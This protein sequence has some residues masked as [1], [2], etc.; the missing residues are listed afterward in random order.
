MKITQRLIPAV[1]KDT[2]PGIKMVPQYITIH[3]TDNTSP[4][5]NAE[6]HARLQERGNDRT[7]SWHLQIDDKE[8]IQSIPFDELAWAAGDGR[9]G[10]GNTKS[11]HIEICVN[12]DGNFKKS[13]ENAAEITKQLMA[14]YNIPITKVVQHNHWSGKS[15]PRFL[16]S[17]DKGVSWNDFIS[18]VQSGVKGV[19]NTVVQGLGVIEM[20]DNSVVR[21]SP[22]AYS[23]IVGNVKKGDKFIVHTVNGDWF[24]IGGWVYKDQVILEWYDVVI[25]GFHEFEIDEALAQVKKAFPN[26]HI[27]KRQQ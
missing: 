24:N 9:N 3:E 15:C 20:S 18:M 1:N 2:R 6:A 19:E 5:A 8:A 17:G 11:I 12:S 7:A 23:E 25:G 26:W 13:V 14:T 10:P 4:G 16:R 21:K 22:T 27:E